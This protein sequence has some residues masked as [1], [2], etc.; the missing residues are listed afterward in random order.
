MGRR[1]FVICAQS[2][3]PNSSRAQAVTRED[4]AVQLRRLMVMPEEG[5]RPRALLALPGAGGLL[6][7][8]LAAVEREA[9]AG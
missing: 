5:L 6:A 7:C 2:L 3:S 9:D 1:Y 8:I 4:A